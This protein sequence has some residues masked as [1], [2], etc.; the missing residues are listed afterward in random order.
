MPGP[1]ME[2][3][4]RCCRP[5]VMG[6][7]ERRSD[8]NT[9]RSQRSYVSRVSERFQRRWGRWDAGVDDDTGRNW[10]K[11]RR[12]LER[13]MLAPGSSRQLSTADRAA[14]GFDVDNFV[15]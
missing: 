11:G 5:G 1:R 7:G 9:A 10:A 6:T 15:I 13:R 14:T 12:S 2:S 3:R 4:R 8:A